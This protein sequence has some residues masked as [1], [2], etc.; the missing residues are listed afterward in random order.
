LLLCLV[1]SPSYPRAQ[2]GTTGDVVV[3]RV[4]F[5][6]GEIRG[7]LRNNASHR[8]RDVELLIR[9]FWVWEARHRAS[10]PGPELAFNYTV[11]QEIPP[12]GSIPFSYTSPPLPARADGYYD[13]SVVVARSVNVDS[14]HSPVSGTKSDKS[15]G[16]KTRREVARIVE[17][18]GLTV[19]GPAVSG[20]LRNKAPHR[21]RDVE[22]LI[23]HVWIPKNEFEPSQQDPGKST[24]YTVRG[25]I[26][27]GGS[28]PFTY[29]ASPLPD[30][31]DGQFQ[32][33]VAV[34]G[35]AEVG[36]GQAKQDRDA[37]QIRL[38][39]LTRATQSGRDAATL[40]A[41]VGDPS[42]IQAVEIWLNGEKATS[43]EL[44]IDPGNRERI[45]IKRTFVLPRFGD[46]CVAIAATDARG[47][48]AISKEACLYRA[49]SPREQRVAPR[50]LPNRPPGS[51]QTAAPVMPERSG[52]AMRDAAGPRIE[53]LRPRPGANI[54]V[55]T[56]MFEATLDD[57]SGIENVVVWLN[58]QKVPST[59]GGSEPRGRKR[60]TI[61]RAIAVS[62]VGI[63]CFGLS[64]RDVNGNTARKQVCLVTRR[65]AVPG[66]AAAEVSS[67]AEVRSAPVVR[68]AAEVRSEGAAAGAK[69]APPVTPPAA[70]RPAT[71]ERVMVP[72]PDGPRDA[73][74]PPLQS[75]SVGM[76]SGKSQP[77]SM[78]AKIE[79]LKRHY[80]EERIT[81]EQFDRAVR[82]LESGV[83]NR[84]LEDFL[85]GEI[86]VSTFRRVF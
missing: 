86:S 49:A 15:P 54:G 69:A 58:E 51:R 79:L 16:L 14:P 75:Q 12:R 68:S 26:E 55:G 83:K 56:V 23:R 3:E 45:Q 13:I 25:D 38:G 9:Y 81:A 62:R 57:D 33:K 77:I 11:R 19:K 80:L 27:P 44:K 37:P 65:Q 40:E 52:A 34:A 20:I 1:Y 59:T 18:E 10:A 2:S 5:R 42:G 70:V 67:T 72:P 41:T 8:V 82:T 28:I 6:D 84:M 66:Q 47:N 46:N 60:I 21:I 43:G 64:A 29:D 35:F 74:G 53:L 7:V 4:E 24:Y 22:L 48:S 17:V 39:D 32:T 73:T 31:T 85:N 36:P 50:I 71:S 63:N 61:K 78:D 30:R 76:A